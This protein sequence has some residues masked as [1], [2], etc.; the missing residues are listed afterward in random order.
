MLILNRASREEDSDTESL[1]LKRN[2][3]RGCSSTSCGQRDRRGSTSIKPIESTSLS[4]NSLERSTP[5]KSKQVFTIKKKNLD[6]LRSL[7]LFPLKT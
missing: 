4:N 7:G 1:Y 6:F 3:V 2:Y 5:N